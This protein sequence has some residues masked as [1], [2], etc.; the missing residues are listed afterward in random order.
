MAGREEGKESCYCMV[1]VASSCSRVVIA[2]A[3]GRVAVV[4]SRCGIV[5][6]SL[7]CCVRRVVGVMVVSHRAVVVASF[8]VVGCHGRDQSW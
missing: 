8:V 3:G 2:S 6:A 7:R 4:L 1:V 5:I